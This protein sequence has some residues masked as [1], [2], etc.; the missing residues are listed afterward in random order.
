MIAAAD[1]PHCAS[2]TLWVEFVTVAGVVVG[3]EWECPVC[4]FLEYET[5][6]VTGDSA[7]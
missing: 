5:K 4:G 1:C 3:L 7:S 2:D 6:E